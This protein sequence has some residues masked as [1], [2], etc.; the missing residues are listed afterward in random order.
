MTINP[1]LTE[2]YDTY[3]RQCQGILYPQYEQRMPSHGRQ[4][5]AKLCYFG[6][7]PRSN[8]PTSN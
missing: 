7:G 6:T 4:Q 3:L 2:K 8:K 1:F 5:R